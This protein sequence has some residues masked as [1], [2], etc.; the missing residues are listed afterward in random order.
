MTINKAQGWSK[1]GRLH[2]GDTFPPTPPKTPPGHVTPVVKLLNF[3]M[4]QKVNG[5]LE[6]HKFINK[7]KLVNLANE[8][9][10]KNNVSVVDTME[11][12][13]FFAIYGV[14][15]ANESIQTLLPRI[16]QI[17]PE[18]V[19]NQLE[20]DYPAGG[21]LALVF[22][23]LKIEEQGKL[24]Q[25]YKL[26]ELFNVKKDLT[27]YL[28]LHNFDF[29]G[30]TDP[31]P[32]FVKLLNSDLVADEYKQCIRNV[33]PHITKYVP[34]D[35][36]LINI[37]SHGH[38][39]INKSKLTKE[40]QLEDFH[41]FQDFVT[42]HYGSIYNASQGFRDPG[43][44]DIVNTCE[45]RLQF[46]PMQAIPLPPTPPPPYTI[47]SNGECMCLHCVCKACVLF[48]EPRFGASWSTT[49]ESHMLITHSLART[50]A[51]LATQS[52]VRSLARLVV[53]VPDDRYRGP[54]LDLQSF[55]ILSV[56][57]YVYIDVK[58]ILGL[59]LWLSKRD[60]SLTGD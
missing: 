2:P 20:S 36:S 7:T 22:D 28:V 59:L 32:Q 12:L 33:L 1:L 23:T 60:T 15:H 48:T 9:S 45:K 21:K 26:E 30:G 31:L 11:L 50:L 53:R 29:D 56:K 13:H 3:T 54:S 25:L 4:Y 16:E 38:Y 19:L 18:A 17:G 40:G 51:S 42:S 49:I 5:I 10:F 57:Q 37:I 8:L 44:L 52:L 43:V 39:Y 35:P 6:P 46:I 58:L 47:R 24:D 14:D 27:C 55:R 41:K 34:Q